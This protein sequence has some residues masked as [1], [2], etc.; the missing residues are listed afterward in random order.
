MGI[1][2]V[3]PDSFSDG[4]RFFGIDAALARATEMV[5]EGAAIIDVGPESSRPGAQSVHPDEQIR[6]SVPVIQAIRKDHPDVLISVDTASSVV[7]AAALQAGAD[8]INDITALRGDPRMA[9]LAAE[10][11]A[12]VVLMHMRGTPA[13]MQE[14]AS[15]QDVVREV[16]DFLRERI[17]AA[18]SAGIPASRLVIDPGVGF[19]KTSEHNC[20]L[21][22]R[23][24]ELVALGPPVLLGA[25]RKSVV[26]GFV[27]TDP[28]T[29]L[30]GS[31]MCALAGVLAGAKILRVHDVRQTADLQNAFVPVIV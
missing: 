9:A 7:A 20:A 8:L 14:Q 19:G 2:N 24:N 23:L 11:G 4:G 30:G 28:I 18:V 22:R 17:D 21:V 29:V 16:K 5:A 10:S 13:N 12:G 27:G 6:R 15:Y 26:R 25:S 1:L 3:T 31:L